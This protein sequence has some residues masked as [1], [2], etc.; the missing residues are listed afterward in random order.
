MI[1]TQQMV[2]LGVILNSTSFRASPAL[3]RV[4]KLLSIGDVFLSCVRQPASSWL[5]LLGVLASMI[6]LVLGGRLRMRSLQLALQRQWDHVD[7]SQI[8]EWSQEIRQDLDWWLDRDRLELGI[9]LEQVSPQLELW[10]D[11]SGLG[12]GAHFDESVSSGLWAPEEVELSIN[13]RELLAIERALLWFAPHLFGSSVAIFADNSTAI[14]YLRNQGGT[15]S[16]LLNSIAQRILHWA[17]SLPVVISPQFIMGKHNVLA[18][19]L[20]RPNQILSSEWILK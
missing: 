16:S 10:S 1:P 11:A 15:H 8:V 7:Q 5:E 14:A 13:V 3:K 2:Y 18:D 6:Q 4:E 20:S 17:E 12:W 9:S 19:S